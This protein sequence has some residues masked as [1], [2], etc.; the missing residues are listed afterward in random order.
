M[1]ARTYVCGSAGIIKRLDNLLGVGVSGVNPNWVNVPLAAGGI[2]GGNTFT[3]Y[4]VETDP[5]NG[6]R[7]I[8]VGDC[9]LGTNPSYFGIALSTNK[10]VNWLIPGGTYGTD[11]TNLGIVP[12]FREVTWV[13]TQTIYVVEQSGVVIKS[14]DGGA[15]FALC[16]GALPAAFRDAW[17]IHFPTPLTGVVGGTDRIAL[18]TDGGVTWSALNGGFTFT[19]TGTAAGKIVG[20]LMIPS[21]NSITAVGETNLLLSINLGVSFNV[22]APLSGIGRHLTWFGNGT[23]TTV[24]TTSNGTRIIGFA[25]FTS[26]AIVTDAT[27]IGGY[28]VRAA[29]LYGINS[30]FLGGLTLGASQVFHSTN[31]FGSLTL[32]DAIV[33]DTEAVWTWVDPNPP[34]PTCYLLTDCDNLVPSILTNTDLSLYVGLIVK[35]VGNTTCWNV[36]EAPGCQGSVPVT[37]LN[38]YDTCIDCAPVCYLLVDCVTQETIKVSDDYGVYVGKIVNLANSGTRCWE[39]FIAPDCVDSIDSGTT[40][41]TVYDTCAQCAPIVIPP[42]VDLHPRRVKPG[43]YTAGCDP[44]Y[45]ERVSCTFAEQVYDTMLRKR[46]GITVCCDEDLDKWDI[47]KQLLDLKA[48][49]DPNICKST[50]SRCCPPTCLTAELQVFNPILSCDP[51]SAVTADLDIPPSTCPPPQNVTSGLNLFPTMPCV[52]YLITLQSIGEECTFEYADCDGHPQ[53]ILISSSAYVCS[54]VQPTS[55]CVAPYIIQT[56]ASDCSNGTCGP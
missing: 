4:D 5:T 20:I 36:A 30:G 9:N 54:I 41:T 47:K 43:Y 38:S 6:D 33:E 42:P 26:G 3:L 19:Q 44:A 32:Q 50:L 15:T 52:C 21:L 23:N 56:T 11:I 24:V 45:T 7:V 18:T 46:Y 51:P 8:A 37:I 35:L 12:V 1:I 27:T 31:D 49:Y 39:V 10:G 48:L 25:G 22:P 40:V 17:S 14:T 2:T 16:A 29:H 13:D 34:E 53:T 28:D 55:L